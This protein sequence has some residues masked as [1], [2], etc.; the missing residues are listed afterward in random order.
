MDKSAKACPQ[1]GAPSKSKAGGI[2]AGV[3]IAIVIIS[4]AAGSSGNKNSTGTPTVV[5]QAEANEASQVSS[6]NNSTESLESETAE[7]TPNNIFHV[8]DIIDTGKATITFK[9][10]DDYT[11][12]NEFMQPKEG[13]KLI[14]AYF[15]IENTG[16]SDL[17]TGSFDFSCYADNSAAESHYFDEKA[18]PEDSLSPGRKKEG[19][20]WYEVPVNAEKIEI[21]Y[22]M[23]W[24]TQ[25]KAIFIVK[26]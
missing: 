11:T 20:V 23:S 9:S 7:K 10:A 4:I 1:C 5:S 2:I 12:D 18:L 14:C 26:E 6:E 25:E 22:E 16:D 15:I 17:F 21:E 24:W 3:V 8:G 13:H 19:Y